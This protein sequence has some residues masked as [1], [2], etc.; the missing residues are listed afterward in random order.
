MQARLYAANDILL[1]FQQQASQNSHALDLIS[2]EH[3]SFC[4]IE[5]V[6]A[7]SVIYRPLNLF[8]HC[9]DVASHHAKLHYTRWSTDGYITFPSLGV[10]INIDVVNCYPELWKL[11]ACSLHVQPCDPSTHATVLCR[12]V[13]HKKAMTSHNR[14]CIIVPLINPSSSYSSIL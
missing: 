13:R 12:L 14:W 2:L 4:L 6:L 1:K 3:Y 7:F 9:T 8:R 10:N 5:S 11:T